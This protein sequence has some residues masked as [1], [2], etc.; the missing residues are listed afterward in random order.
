MRIKLTEKEISEIVVD[1]LDQ[2]LGERSP[3][4]LLIA[5]SLRESFREAG[6]KELSSAFERVG[7]SYD[8]S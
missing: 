4:A 1:A 5:E 6:E 3:K 2:H 8:Y 7:A